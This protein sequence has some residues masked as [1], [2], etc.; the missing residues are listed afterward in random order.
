M[1]LLDADLLTQLKMSKP[2]QPIL[3]SLNLSLQDHHSLCK[4]QTLHKRHQVPTCYHNGIILSTGSCYSYN[5]LNNG[6]LY[7]KPHF[8][9]C[10]NG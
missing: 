7:C 8:T 3:Y 6:L 10:K 5:G 1:K 4:S 2:K 9:L